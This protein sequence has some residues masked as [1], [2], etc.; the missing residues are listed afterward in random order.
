MTQPSLPNVKIPVPAGNRGKDWES[1]LARTHDHYRAIGLGVVFHIPNSWRYGGRPKQ[2]ADSARHAATGDGRTLKRVKSAPDFVGSLSGRG[3][4]FDAKSFSGASIP[5]DQFD[6]DRS[7]KQ[8]EDLHDAW[9]GGNLA[10][11]MVLEK[12]TMRVHWVEAEYVY[13]WR[14]NVT[15]GIKGTAKS[16]N[17]SEVVDHRIR[18][19]GVC[20]GFRFDYA[21]LLIPACSTR[22]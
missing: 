22:E 6:E 9:R 12:R 8:I 1:I 18:L 3:I 4:V 5:Y 16:I 11:Y 2:G 19:L 20:D 15:R 21:P 17:F 13:K 7:G 10:G 14:W